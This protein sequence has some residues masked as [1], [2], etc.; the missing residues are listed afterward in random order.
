MSKVEN[1]RFAILTLDFGPRDLGPTPGRDTLFHREKPEEVGPHP[2]RL[3]SAGRP[4]A[5][6]DGRGGKNGTGHERD[7]TRLI[8][9]KVQKSN[10][11]AR[12]PDFGLWTAGLW[13]NCGTGH[14]V[15]PRKARRNWPSSRP[16]PIRR[17]GTGEGGRMGRDSSG[18]GHVDRVQSP[19]SK[20]ENQRLAIRTLDFGPPDFGLT[21]GRDTLFHREKHQAKC[22]SSTK[23]GAGC[24]RPVLLQELIWFSD[25]P[26]GYR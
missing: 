6:P 24:L 7:G 25:R 12:D 21:P 17:A 22:R 13:T 9:S 4:S 3:S 10:V 5:E 8:G 18:T 20:V 26:G 14:V 16:S 15:S 23:S 1:Q 11:E 2:V 19:M